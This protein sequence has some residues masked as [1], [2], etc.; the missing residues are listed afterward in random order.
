VS[1]I[2]DV[3]DMAKNTIHLLTDEK[4]LTQMKANALER[5]KHFDLVKILPMY[6]NY[7]KKIIDQSWKFPNQSN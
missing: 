1:K 4:L 7:Y 3:N 6:E 5:A 2:G